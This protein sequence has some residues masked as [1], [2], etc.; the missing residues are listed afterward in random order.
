MLAEMQARLARS[1][2]D[3]L[4]IRD[5]AAGPAEVRT[6][7]LELTKTYHPAKYARMSTDIQRLAN[8]VF[9]ALRSAH[10]QLAR[11]KAAVPRQTGP[12]PA[13]GAGKPA[14]PTNGASPRAPTAPAAGMARAPVQ[15]TTTPRTN[16]PPPPSAAI[17]APTQ[18][19]PGLPPPPSPA[20]SAGT[21]RGPGVSQQMPAV[22][23]R[24]AHSP[25]PRT[26]APLRRPTPVGG[27]PAVPATGVRPSLTQPTPVAATKPSS[28][29]ELVGVYDLLQKGHWEQARTTL[30]ALI[31]LQ[32]R[33]R[34][35]A[36]VAYSLGREAQLARRIDEARVELQN[37]LEIDPELQL[38]KT[39]LGE[40]FTRRK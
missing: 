12:I 22:P 35:H 7:F 27:V 18:R 29:P 1:P 15:A 10:D 26:A 13:L 20:L 37:A 5:G 39:A 3:A 2:H 16:V 32:P 31:A 14:A 30:N 17:N 34:Y 8:E 6:A 40:L 23:P 25:M 9:L 38:A 21:Q 24:P 28:E 33:P 11:P 19:G 36:L 4:G